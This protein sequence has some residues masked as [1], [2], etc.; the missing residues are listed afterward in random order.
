MLNIEQKKKMKNYCKR[1]KNAIRV[2]IWAFKNPKTMNESN[3]KMLS[4]TLTLILKVAEE[5]RPYMNKIAIVLPT[6]EH[7]E[8]VSI[9]AGAGIGA[10]PTKRI[11]ELLN[12]N[13]K[14]RAELIK[15]NK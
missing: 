13:S 12:E 3:F 8:V 9:W 4:D 15:L 14:L 10:E 11:T 1:I 5:R 2:G 6:G 7:E